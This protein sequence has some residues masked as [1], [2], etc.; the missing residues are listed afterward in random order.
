MLFLCA[1]LAGA[2]LV[3]APSSA[4]AAFQVRI[5]T[6]GGATFGAAVSDG[7]LG[8][9]N[10]L[11]GAITVDIGGL[12]ITAV[13]SGGTSATL[14]VLDL[15][16]QQIGLGTTAPGNVVV[17]ASLTDLVTAPPPLFLINRFGDATLPVGGDTVATARTWIDQSNTIFGTTGGGIKVDTGDLLP[18]APATTTFGSF[19]ANPLYSITAQIHTTFD[20][21]VALGLDSNNRIVNTPAPAGAVLAVIGLPVLCWL[22]RRQ[23]RMAA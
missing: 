9:Q 17:Q 16:V 3:W 6:D 19:T 12:S 11:A 1:V 7:G 23:N 2:A 18:T 10:G 14:S 8:D 4:D 22:R 21:G 15:Q 13:A 5:S 20:A